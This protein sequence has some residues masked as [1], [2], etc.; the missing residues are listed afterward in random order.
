MS[1]VVLFQVLQFHLLLSSLFV[2]SFMNMNNIYIFV[3][4]LHIFH[5]VKQI[6]CQTLDRLQS[7]NQQ[8]LVQ[9]KIP[10][11]YKGKLVL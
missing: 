1:S 11:I 9:I 2:H 6:L 3:W 5:T 10:S 7:D 4:F 8:T